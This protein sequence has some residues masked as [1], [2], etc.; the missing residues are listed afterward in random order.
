LTP[1]FDQDYLRRLQQG[2]PETARHF[3]AYFGQLLFFK[4][5]NR[6]HTPQ[7]LAEIRQETFLRVLTALRE[8][9]IEHPERLG[10]FV[11]AVC[12]N[13][14]KEFVR[15]EIRWAP[16][17]DNAPEPIDSRAEIDQELIS[18]ERTEQVASVLNELSEKDRSVLRML[19][20]EE[21]AKSEVCQKLGVAPDYLRVVLHRAK[22]RFRER[23]V[24]NTLAAGRR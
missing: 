8:G 19:F 3:N 23:F 20:L 15:M 22:G 7:M 17:G 18:R 2:D 12:N 13:I 14:L 24:E 4:L 16:G 1:Q 9:A 6:V 11:C 5:R 10:A 21:R